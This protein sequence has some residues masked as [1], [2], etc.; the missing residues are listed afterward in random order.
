M[1]E[2]QKHPDGPWWRSNLLALVCILVFGAIL[3]GHTLNAP[4]Y[5][6]DE[7]AILENTTIHHLDQA[8]VDLLSMRGLA[9]LTFALNYRFG[10]TEVSGYHLVNIAIHLL[11]S[12]LVFFILK[13]VF[14]GRP[15]LV[16]GGALL[17]VAHPLQ[18]QAVTYI[19]QRMTSL[20]ALF[21]FLAL[22]LY[23]RA[24]ETQESATGTA[25]TRSWLFYG[26]ALFCGAL[27]VYTKQNA[28][29]LPLALILFDRYFLPQGDKK[30]WARLLL[31][32]VPFFL[33]PFWLGVQS[34]LM[35]MLSPEGLGNIGGL[36]D[37][38]HLRHNSPLNY[39]VTQFTVIWIYLRLLIFPY[40]L[41]LDYD[42]PIVA[43]LWHWP[44]MVGLLGIVGLLTAA[45]LLRKRQPVLSAGIFWFFLTLAIES[46]II[47]LDPVFEHRLYLPMF[48]FVL[49]VMGCLAL[50]PRRFTIPAVVLITGVVAVLTWQRNALWNDPV[51]FL[52][53]NL[54]SAPRSE[55]VRLD[56]GNLYLKAKR[57]DEAQRVY[58]EALAINP[59]YVLIHINL[60]RAYVAQKEYQKA[61]AI[62]EEGI[63]RDPS[64][65]KLY[66]NLGVVYNMLGNFPSAVATLQRATHIES[67]NATVY[68][69][70]G[71]AY[72]RLG[73]LDEAIANFRRST[74]LGNSDPAT[75][76]NLGLALHK[77]G[78]RQSALQE[79]LVASRLNPSHA[80]SLFN[81]GM[82]YI[83]LGNQMAARD[84]A[85][86]LQTL[87]PG[88]ARQLESR[89]N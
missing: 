45:T 10:G 68:F 22:F 46:S 54:R 48:G 32:V 39:L 6:D 25:P 3:Y 77:K 23:I 56:L 49:V 61:A 8:L 24:R 81:A 28:A 73:R 34:L 72:D 65:F 33:V 40:G 51:A 50:L 9:N 41:T 57:V 52:E 18:T 27:A 42:L 69:N 66:N 36:P 16:L 17:F 76:F 29:V 14:T 44:G 30:P 75:H 21:F 62:L 78:E 35:P 58:E 15:L 47:P 5:L 64:H 19:V 60:A 38:I 80:G 87:N 71:I 2:L 37:L 53:D 11:S 67:G 26:G 1:S 13:R 84:V 7:R 20:A 86:Q 82:V 89:I 79:F 12:C 43:N 59:G 55:R 74:A 31:Y 4:W 70:L 63:R 88:M 83:E 85:A